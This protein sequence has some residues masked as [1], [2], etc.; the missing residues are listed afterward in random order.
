V[1]RESEGRQE[2]GGIDELLAD[3]S[4]EEIMEILRGILLDEVSHILRVPRDKIDIGRPLP[5]IG[6]DSLMAVELKLGLERRL[7]IDVPALV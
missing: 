5:E 6:M 4:P 2:G 1:I 7:N 3:K